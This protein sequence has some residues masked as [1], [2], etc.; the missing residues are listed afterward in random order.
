MPWLLVGSLV[1]LLCVQFLIPITRDALC[2]CV[3]WT[4]G[5]DLL[6]GVSARVDTH[7]L[8]RDLSCDSASEASMI[9]AVFPCDFEPCLCYDLVKTLR[10]YLLPIVCRANAAFG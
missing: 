6:S 5:C 7:D 2:F 3:I 8:N 10:E 4:S 1:L 9:S